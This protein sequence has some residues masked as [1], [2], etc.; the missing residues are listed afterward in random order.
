M[1]TFK[2]HYFRRF[3]NIC[4]ANEASFSELP[5]QAQALM[6]IKTFQESREVLKASEGKHLAQ[7][8]ELLLSESK[9]KGDSLGVAQKC[10]KLIDLWLTEQFR[11]LPIDEPIV[12]I[13][14]VPACASPNQY[15]EMILHCEARFASDRDT[16]KRTVVRR[17]VPTEADCPRVAHCK[18]RQVGYSH[19]FARIEPYTNL[20]WS[21]WSLSE[22]FEVAG[23]SH[24]ILEKVFEARQGE[25]DEVVNRLAGE[26]NRLNEI[27]SR[28]KCRECSERLVFSKQYS[29]KDAV[30]RATVT[31]PCSTV[32]C[33]GPSVYLSHCRGC[34]ATIDSRE[35]VF[36]DKDNFYICIECASG[37]DLEKAG[38]FCPKCGERNYLRGNYRKKK[39]SRTECGHRVELPFKALRSKFSTRQEGNFDISDSWPS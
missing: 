15:V 11:D 4:E 22:L 28:C 30:Y 2:Q 6:L 37:N 33:S 14:L 17:H 9:T 39:C 23:I 25:G 18:K 19:G 35:S 29:V 34:T 32:G 8:V 1:S 16:E 20:N 21:E 5:D 26:I 12:A 36:K 13:P 24:A 10:R 3:V 27:R 31:N 7:V 38:E